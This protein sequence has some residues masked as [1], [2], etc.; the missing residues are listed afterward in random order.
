MIAPMKNIRIKKEYYWMELDGDSLK[1]PRPAGYYENY[2]YLNKSNV[3]DKKDAERRLQEYFEHGG[4]GEY[5]LC[6]K[7]SVDRD[8]GS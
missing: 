6:E 1:E 3:I 2:L 4:N 8:H 7:Y 5:I